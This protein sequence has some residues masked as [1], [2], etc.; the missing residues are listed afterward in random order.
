MTSSVV[1]GYYTTPEIKGESVLSIS[2]EIAT[3]VNPMS[4]QEVKVSGY[5]DKIWISNINEPSD[6]YVY[7]TD[8]KLVGNI[9]DALGSVSLSVQGEQLYLVKVGDRTFKLTM[10]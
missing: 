6:V 4:L 1:N 8:G 9:S 7:S 10:P 3:D 5:N 2:Y